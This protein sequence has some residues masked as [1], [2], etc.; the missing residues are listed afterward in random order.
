MKRKRLSVPNFLAEY[1]HL[2]HSIEEDDNN[3]HLQKSAAARRRIGIAR[4]LLD[5]EIQKLLHAAEEDLLVAARRS[6]T[7]DHLIFSAELNELKKAM[8]F[9]KWSVNEDDNKVPDFENYDIERDM[10]EIEQ[11]APQWTALLRTL[12]LPTRAG[13]ASYDGRRDGEDD[14][15]QR[16][17]YFI[18]SMLMHKRSPKQGVFAFI[19]FGLWLEG[20][21]ASDRTILSLQKFGICPNIKTIQKRMGSL[22]L[23][24]KVRDSST[25]NSHS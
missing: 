18:T 19:Q 14:K 16:L 8:A 21:G 11:K 7:L 6:A 25:S 2:D 17:I 5:V 20:Q 12:T 15:T 9:R 3:A 1:I 10:I 4:T 22:Q 13:W 24:A 23:Y